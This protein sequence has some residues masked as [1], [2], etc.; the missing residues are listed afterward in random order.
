MFAILRKN[1]ITL[2]KILS[3]HYCVGHS[4]YPKKAR[5]TK[6]TKSDVI[7][8]EATMHPEGS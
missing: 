1:C 5:K 6:G 4:C 7:V 8:H 2:Y 3:K